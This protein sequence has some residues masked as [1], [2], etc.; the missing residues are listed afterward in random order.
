MGQGRRGREGAGPGEV[1]EP[2]CLSVQVFLNWHLLTPGLWTVNRSGN[3][4]ETQQSVVGVGDRIVSVLPRKGVSW[5]VPV[6]HISWSL[7]SSLH[8]LGVGP[9]QEG[10]GAVDGFA[11]ALPPIT[12]CL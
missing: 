8:S 12:S 6:T 4:V 10:G 3:E 9:G 1:P 2:V 11:S 7:H 5:S